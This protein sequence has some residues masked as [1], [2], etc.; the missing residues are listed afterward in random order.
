MNPGD[1]RHPESKEDTRL[2][3]ALRGIP[4]RRPPEE[5]RDEILASAIPRQEASTAGSWSTG[6]S[7]WA[8]GWGVVACA[9][10]L[11]IVMNR[12]AAA[13]VGEAPLDRPPP[14]A[15]L[16]ELLREQRLAMAL[17]MVFIRT[18]SPSRAASPNF[19]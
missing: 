5:W 3:Q 6:G 2:E 16:V 14:S 10:A 8:S 9:W 7:W 12:F 17:G 15:A 18:T 4:W 1:N 11:V 13:P 19:R